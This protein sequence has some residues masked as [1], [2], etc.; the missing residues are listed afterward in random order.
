M[1][2]VAEDL[3][4]TVLKFK[5]VAKAKG[6]RY[7][8]AAAKKDA[9]EKKIMTGTSEHMTTL[10]ASMSKSKSL[11]SSLEESKM[12]QITPNNLGRRGSRNAPNSSH[13]PS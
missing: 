2:K 8:I 4:E 7:E 13:F 6:I 5:A 11:L 12:S 9:I 3:S 1:L 10:E